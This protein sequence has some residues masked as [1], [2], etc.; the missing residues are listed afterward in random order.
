MWRASPRVNCR[1]TRGGRTPL[2]G[3]FISGQPGSLRLPTKGEE[4]PFSDEP[5]ARPTLRRHHL[6]RAQSSHAWPQTALWTALQESSCSKPLRL[7]HSQVYPFRGS[8]QVLQPLNQTSVTNLVT[9]QLVNN[10]YI[11]NFSVQITVWFLFSLD[12]VA[13]KQWGWH[14]VAWCP[15]GTG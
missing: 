12:L 5:V 10:A 2:F 7:Q 8:G 13:L 3:S 15:C 6:P 4:E 9:L 1:R 14:T 11:F